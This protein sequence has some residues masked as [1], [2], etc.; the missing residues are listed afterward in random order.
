MWAGDIAAECLTAEGRVK[1]EQTTSLRA[2]STGSG[3]AEAALDASYNEE[4][5]L[6]NGTSKREDQASLR[7]PKSS[8]TVNN[9]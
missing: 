8:E 7:R 1:S 2:S 9:S 4:Y 3:A 6:A 5:E